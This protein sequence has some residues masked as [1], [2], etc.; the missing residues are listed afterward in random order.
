MMKE[1]IQAHRIDMQNFRILKILLENKFNRNII[2][3]LNCNRRDDTF[4]LEDDRRSQE[5]IHR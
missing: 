1:E 2:Y 3:S 4:Q 5:Y